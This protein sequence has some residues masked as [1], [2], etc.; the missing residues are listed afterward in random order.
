[1]KINAYASYVPKEEL[2]SF[3]YE[4]APKENEIVVSINSCSITR[5]DIRFID[6]YWNDTNYPMVPGLEIIGK[7]TE[8]GKDVKDIKI[9]DIVGI[10]YQVE[11]C[12][13][14]EY[15]LAGKEQFCLNQKLI[16]VHGYGGLADTIIVDYRFAFKIP[17]NLQSP[18]A[19]PLL[20]SGLTPYAAIKKC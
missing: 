10:G 13:T 18:D 19:T 6:N 3:T 9:G 8:I 11:S 16:P 2:K 4:R 14:C 1:M 7:V 20:C 17:E 12:F 5:G 15:C